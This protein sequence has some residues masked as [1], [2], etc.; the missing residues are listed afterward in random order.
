MTHEK[1]T[2]EQ[3]KSVYKNLMADPRNSAG[4]HE[5][6]QISGKQVPYHIYTKQVIADVAC[7]SVD[8]VKCWLSGH[9]DCPAPCWKLIKNSIV[10]KKTGGIE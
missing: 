9:R 3:I 10:D 8:T 4:Y 6:N 5:E 1:P 7:V 2:K